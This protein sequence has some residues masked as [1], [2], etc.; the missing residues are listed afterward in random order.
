MGLV[1]MASVAPLQFRVSV[2]KAL[3]RAF[4]LQIK[5][6]W[7]HFAVPRGETLTVNRVLYGCKAIVENI[8]ELETDPTAQVCLYYFDD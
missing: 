2:H 6:G 5:S 7:L 8:S 3:R 4:P 1:F